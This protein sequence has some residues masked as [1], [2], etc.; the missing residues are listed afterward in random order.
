MKQN[1]ERDRTYGNGFVAAVDA[2]LAA[3]SVAHFRG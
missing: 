3:Q 2:A 1:R